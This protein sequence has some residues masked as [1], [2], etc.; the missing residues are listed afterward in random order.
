MDDNLKKKI[1]KLFM[2]GTPAS[3]VTEEFESICKKY[4]LGNFCVKSNDARS[5]EKLCDTT[6]SLRRLG[7]ETQDEYPFVKG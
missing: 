1:G 3:G 5:V 4:F 6:A 7:Y 2:I